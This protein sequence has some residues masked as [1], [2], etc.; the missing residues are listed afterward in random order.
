MNSVLSA[1]EI[2]ALVSADPPLVEAWRNLEEQVQPSGFDLTLREVAVP[3]GGGRITESNDNRYIPEVS[4]LMFDG[5]GYIDLIPGYYIIT[6]NEV[7]NIPRDMMALA[8]P[9]SSLLRAGAT[10]HTA[11]WDPG[12]S[13]RSRSLLVVF[14]TQGLRLQRN[15]RLLQLVFFRLGSKTEGYDGAYQNENK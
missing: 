2:R 3:Q 7:V 5:L 9:R 15:A 6:Y 13:G 10:I 14:N 11:V 12:Y 1:A 8:A 4:P